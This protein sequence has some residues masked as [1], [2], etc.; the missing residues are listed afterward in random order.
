[1]LKGR[2]TEQETNLIHHM[3][4]WMLFL[5]QHPRRTRKI[6]THID[7]DSVTLEKIGRCRN[8]VKKEHLGRTMTLLYGKFA[9]VLDI[10]LNNSHS[11][12]D[13]S[14]GLQQYSWIGSAALGPQGASTS[15][16]ML[17]RL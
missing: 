14:R 8:P 11:S 6:T 15:N 2:K 5:Q 16:E 4:H 7:P 10:S 12:T 9:A 1:M 13:I 3:G 17:F